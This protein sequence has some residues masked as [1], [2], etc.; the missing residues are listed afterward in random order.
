MIRRVLLAIGAIV[1]PIASFGILSRRASR[2]LLQPPRTDP[3]ETGPGP[4]IDAL[5]GEVVRF[6]SRDGLRLAGRWLAAEPDDPGWTSDPHEAVLLLHGWSGSSAPDVVEYGPFLRQTAGVL[7]FDFRGHGGSDDGST[8]F[9]MHEVEDIA[10]ALAWLGERGIDR[11]AMVG[12][13]MGGL[14]AIASVAVLG[15]GSLPSADADPAAPAHVA[16]PRRPRIVGVVADS[17]AP[18]LVVAV[19]SRL[20]G[21]ARR[22]MAGR[23]FDAA[24]R[25]LGADPR[26][27]EPARVI[28]LLEGMPLLLISGEADT[29]VPIA[30]ARRLAAAAPPGLEH[31]IVPGA[32]H[33]AAHRTDPAGYESRVT[34]LLRRAFAAGREASPIIAAPER[35][36]GGGHDPASP[37]ED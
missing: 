22:W 24:A 4:A 30:D 9:G 11:V 32:E 18:E 36:R 1:L 5:G 8:T 14:A 28:G 20:R 19:A 15:D 37:L 27:T 31:W 33:R 35:G 3:D 7:G 10:G 29:T 16:P 26:D 12:L 17:A 2:R 34:D 13:S 6:R 23:L 25:S 21:P